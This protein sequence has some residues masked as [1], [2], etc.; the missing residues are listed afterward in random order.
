MKRL[1]FSTVF[2][3]CAALFGW[4]CWVLAYVR[5][6]WWWVVV[7]VIPYVIYQ[8]FFNKDGQED[9]G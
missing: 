4:I 1:R 2:G 9:S 6:N 3:W 7:S 5:G 8:A